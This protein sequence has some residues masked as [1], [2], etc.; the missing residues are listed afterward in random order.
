MA[1]SY[2]A[3]AMVD[4]VLEH[5]DPTRGGLFFDGTLG[6]AGHAVA[7]L[8]RGGE[9]TRLI[10]VDRDPEALDVAARRLERF[11]ARVRLVAGNFADVAEELAG[12]GASLAGAL[13]DLGISSRHIDE[14]ARG[15]SFRPGTPLDMRMGGA[16]AAVPTAAQ[17][18]NRLSHDELTRVFRVYGEEPR[19]RR[20]AGE[21]VRRRELR[22]FATS[23][24]LLEAME[25]A[26][27]SR[28]EVQDKARIFQALRIAVN[29]EME[30]LERALPALRD[31]LEDGGVFVV[32]AYH[33]L[34][35][36]QVKNAFREWSR[37]CVC[38]PELPMCTC[39]GRPLGKTLMRKPLSASAQEVA[40]NPRVRSARLRAWRKAA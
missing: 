6:G 8:E 31:A 14:P 30:A 2:H 35:D 4:E 18:L 39:R 5:L 28:L 15:F 19:A 20:L 36:R 7:I 3:P 29:E 33:S 27:G 21:V 16:A 23:D 24:D 10:A 25:S 40:E 9:D 1:D 22:P 26:L 32:L 12:E 13:L 38:P 11:G 17:L 34:E 37:A